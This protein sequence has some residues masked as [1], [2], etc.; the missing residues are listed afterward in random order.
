MPDIA[1]RTY[2]EQKVAA[3]LAKCREKQRKKLE[4]MLGNPPNLDR[5]PEQFWT[6]ARECESGVLLL[7]LAPVAYAAMG[8]LQKSLGRDDW[9]KPEL[10]KRAKKR[11]K[12]RA[13][14]TSKDAVDWTKEWLKKKIESGPLTD[15]DF[16]EVFGEGRTESTAITE[17]TS[18]NSAAEKD[19]VDHVR[20]G[21]VD[22]Q[23]LWQTEKDASV[24]P[25]CRPL[26]G[27]PEEVWSTKFPD[28]PS[29]HPRCR[30]WLKVI[31][32]GKDKGR[33]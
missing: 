23:I 12:D 6:Q 5:V 8:G 22:V 25:I 31:T 16:E 10:R 20:G 29:A 24:C 13:E 27:Q 11:G 4:V 2:I 14:S 18:T 7:Y 1:N 3:A 26:D 19:Y 9:D 15:D 21:G 32:D 30:C 28:G 33:L 17:V